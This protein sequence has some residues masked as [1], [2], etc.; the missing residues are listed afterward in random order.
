MTVTFV[1]GPTV[2]FISA[3]LRDVFFFLLLPVVEYVEAVRS[4]GRF[5][6]SF[7]VVP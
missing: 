4:V 1:S 2:F 6:H 3:E 7:A 5:V